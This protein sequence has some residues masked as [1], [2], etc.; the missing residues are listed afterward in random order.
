MAANSGPSEAAV[1]EACTVTCR[2]VD[3]ESVVAGWEIALSTDGVSWSFPSTELRGE[4]ERSKDFESHKPNEV[5]FAEG[6]WS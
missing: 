2:R 5:G 4:Y 6:T 3:P 1:R